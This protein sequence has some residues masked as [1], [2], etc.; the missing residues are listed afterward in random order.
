M[1]REYPHK[2]NDDDDSSGFSLLSPIQGARSR[3][4]ELISPGRGDDEFMPNPQAFAQGVTNRY[5]A[6][7][8]RDRP[9]PNIEDYYDE[10][11]YN[12]IIS[13]QINTFASDC[14]EGGWHIT[15]DSEKTVDEITEFAKHM[16]L[17]AGQIHQPISKIG[18]M[19]I[20]QHEV[21][22]TFLG[23]H[24]HDENGRPVGIN[25]VNPSTM[26]IYTKYG[27][28]VLVP[29][30]YKPESNDTTIKRNDEGEV[31]AYVQFD[32]RL[33]SYKNRKERRFTRDEMMHWAR[34]PDIGDVFGKSRIEPV[35][36]RSRSLR[37]KL[38]DNDLA[39]AMKAWPMIL[40]KLGSP[41][42]PYTIDEMEDFMEKYSQDELGPG[43]YQGVPGDVEIEEFAGE[44]ADIKDPVMTDVNMIVS[45]MP[46]PKHNVGAFPGEGENPP[47][48]AHEAQYRKLVRET[49]MQLENLFTPYLKMVA[50]EWGYDP[51]G[52]ELNIGRPDGEVAPEDIEGNV[53]RYDGVTD[54]GNDDSQV[55]GEPA[56]RSVSNPTTDEGDSSDEEQN[57][58]YEQLSADKDNVS[59]TSGLDVATLADPEYDVNLKSDEL[60]EGMIGIDGLH[61]DI[62]SVIGE[63]LTESRSGTMDVVEA[64]NSS[65][66][67]VRAS[68]VASEYESQVGQRS[69]SAKLS[70]VS[71]ESCRALKT[72]V[73][74]GIESEI[75]SISP[76]AAH[77][78][79]V[80]QTR[81][82]IVT[83]VRDLGNEIS[84]QIERN[85][86]E[87]AERDRDL[88]VIDDRLAN[89]Y[90]DHKLK[91]RGT[92]I[93]RM[94]LTEL[95]NRIKL[96]EY[97][98]AS[99]VDGVTVTASCSENTHRLTADLAG[100][101]GD[102]AI[103]TFDDEETVAEQ[104]QGE[105][106]TEP[107]AKFDP[108][109]GVPP[110]HFGSK[111]ELT[112]VREK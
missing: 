73:L 19:A 91:Y 82:K 12:P 23:E 28:N 109:T 44:T 57:E 16:T 106:S 30:D 17:N 89:L 100:C 70:S 43:M 104:L 51:S 34:R 112:P 85:V 1:A 10:Y 33:S 111:A 38:N 96:H 79:L 102:Q 68:S 49:R 97:R 39:I 58:S 59:V 21:R 45:A 81:E 94:R 75:G 24:M 61:E 101:S 67:T 15:A 99:V 107:T 64:R 105:I 69:R 83:D 108:M 50:E 20:I 8:D 56:N 78:S 37:E 11:Q 47:T 53:I 5:S 31:A 52:L 87:I 86:R 2:Q 4:A 46:G 36:A 22:G 48:A 35:L 74:E 7:L 77:R 25:P 14:W 84:A 63:I 71:E 60:A 93:A 26:E 6:E 54:D 95:L 76:D 66:S 65:T 90:S 110:Y 55:A 42:R 13:T 40:F 88:D 80:E 98:K 103:A 18:K 3:V 32:H 41:E 62:G 92:L 9:D 29:S 72:H 27:T